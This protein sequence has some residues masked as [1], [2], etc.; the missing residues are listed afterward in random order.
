M[1]EISPTARRAAAPK[2]GGLPY[3]PKV[4][5]R[6]GRLA[7]C[8]EKPDGL[9]RIFLSPEHRAA[10]ELVMAWMSMAGMTPRLDAIGNVVGRYEGASPGLPALMLGS[11]LDTVRDAG[12]YDGMYGVV[13]SI[14][15]VAA[16]HDAG[17]RLSFAVEVMGF[18]DEEGVRFQSTLLGSRAITGTL[19]LSVLEREDRAGVTMAEALHEFG[20][21]PGKVADA[22]RRPDELLAFVE[23]HIEQGPV[24]ED[25]DLPAGLVTAIAGATRYA[26][27]I[28]GR[29]GHAGTVPMALRQDALAAASEV[30]LA[31]EARCSGVDGLVGTVGHLAVMPDAVNVIPGRVD[32]SLD[33]RAG[34]DTARHA[35]V[36]D[37]LAA[38]EEICARRGLACEVTPTHDAASSACAPWLMDQIGEALT[39]N[40]L[41]PRRLPSG[42]G[43]D[44]MAMA[45]LT[46][47]AMLFLRCEGG[48]SHHPDENITVEDAD[49][50]V[51]VLLSF[52]RAFQP[53]ESKS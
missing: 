15:A 32:L 3:G 29:A 10:A 12:R 27:S 35:A 31:L 5:D 45:E 49:M 52:I 28:T 6:L 48:V 4:M 46:D 42:A 36:Q 11:H 43:H 20:L 44:A 19:D 51:R 16:L 39:A 8:S 7:G 18:A 33:I 26:V 34:D 17:E 47:M 41:E 22:A 30:V 37:I 53:K 21:D 1:T 38:F 2:S 13:A 25:E 24:L 50:G 9:T 23:P 40:G 14:E